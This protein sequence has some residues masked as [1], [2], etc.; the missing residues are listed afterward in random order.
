[1]ATRIRLASFNLENLDDAPGARPSLAERIALMRPQLL[2]IEADVLCR[3]EVRT[4]PD[5]TGALQLLALD[6]FVAGKRYLR[7]QWCARNL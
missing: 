5:P 2:R 4:Q 3:Q 7:L 1:V 6:Q